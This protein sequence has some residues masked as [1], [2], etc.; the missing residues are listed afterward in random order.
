MQNFFVRKYLVGFL[1]IF[2]GIALDQITKWIVHINIPSKNPLKVWWWLSVTPT[3]NTG[4]SWGLFSK[5]GRA[6]QTLFIALSCVLIVSFLYMWWK[7]KKPANQVG[8]TA[9]IAGA[10]G[11]LIDR[12]RFGGVFDFLNVH[13]DT[14][15]FPV[16]NVADMLISVGF[17]ILLRDYYQWKR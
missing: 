11:N 1:G 9:I 6:S 16:F 17:L 3:Y 2:V 15:H 12:I 4:V 13:W 5:T 8:L 14:L 10:L 7:E